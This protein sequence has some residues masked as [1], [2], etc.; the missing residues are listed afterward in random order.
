VQI[1]DRAVRWVDARQRR[2]TPSAFVVGVVKK[3]G[4]DRGGSLS[5]IVTFYGFIA[6]FPLLLLFVTIV[7]I[8][9][10]RSSSAEERIVGSALSQFPVIG[11][12]LRSNI[13]ALSRGS[14]LAFAV[15]ALGLLWGS[16]GITNALQLAS[17][18]MWAVP[19][20]QEPGLPARVWRG[21]QILGITAAAVVLSSILAG[22]STFGATHL[23][24]P[25]VVVRVLTIAGA[26]VLNVGAYLAA[27]RILAPPATPVRR[28][29]PGT[30]LGGLAWTALQ[31]A[32]GYLLSHQLHRA[33][34][35]YGFFAIVLGMIFWLNLG[36][37][38]FLYST[39]VN[40]V[41]HRHLWPRGLTDAPAAGD[42]APGEL[43]PPRTL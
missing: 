24:G 17:A 32:G 23:G 22:V 30:L 13:H 27:L 29:L 28:L 12:H 15:S 3:Y 37:Q 11:T 7:G 21:L 43:S 25:R 18:R 38:L 35:L 1:V 20:H 19:R 8:V 36:S 31:A 33:T 2:F 16:L 34:E 5:A 14:P 4:D 9:V 6:V 42:D 26:A 40:V 39:E 41:L 10:G